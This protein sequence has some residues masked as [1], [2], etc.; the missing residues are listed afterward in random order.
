MLRRTRAFTLIELLVVIAIIGILAA[1]ILPALAQAK[2]HAQRIKC[3]NNQKQIGL[4]FQMWSTDMKDLFTPTAYRTGDYQYQLSWDDYLHAYL[5][6]HDTPDDLQLGLDQNSN[7][8]PG[9]LK[10]PAD[11]IGQGGLTYGNFQQRR[12]YA[13]NYAGEANDPG[14]RPAATHGVGVRITG[15]GGN[16]G[17]LCPWEPPPNLCYKSSDV[18]DFAGTIVLCELPNLGNLAGND[19]P[20][21]CAG[22]GYGVPAWTQQSSTYEI[23]QLTDKQPA[24]LKASFGGVLFGLHDRRF[25]YLFHDGHVAAL[26]PK[27]TV[28]KGTTNA[29]QG[30]WTMTKG[31]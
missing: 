5:G 7:A 21:F 4:A 29:P 14:T 16:S 3:T 1:L 17:Q 10:C 13:M 20:S 18:Q 25:N 8:I 11:R 12:S 27:D 26:R 24:D 19:W 9:V 31:D 23:V 30:M 28:G 15:T 6:G 22:P 2:E